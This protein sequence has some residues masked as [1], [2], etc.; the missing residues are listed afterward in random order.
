VLFRTS[1][2]L[3]SFFCE[4]GLKNGGRSPSHDI[5]KTEVRARVRWGGELRANRVFCQESPIR[6]VG[7]GVSCTRARNWSNIQ[8]H[9]GGKKNK[10]ACPE[11]KA[12]I[13]DLDEKE[14]I[15]GENWVTAENKKLGGSKVE[16]REK[17][18][19]TGKRRVAWSP[20][21]RGKTKHILSQSREDFEE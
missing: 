16:H 12:T 6:R 9:S 13:K 1:E 4:S 20:K 17:R 15:Q 8:Q 21:K 7:R 19:K 5:G 18:G 14:A 3:S 11:G 2:D 10:A